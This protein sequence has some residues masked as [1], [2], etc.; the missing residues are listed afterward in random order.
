[1]WKAIIESNREEI[2][3]A[4]SK[5]QDGLQRIQSAITNGNMAEVVSLL[6]KGKKFRNRLD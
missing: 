1:M 6:E 5:Y 3:R 4:L 2:Q